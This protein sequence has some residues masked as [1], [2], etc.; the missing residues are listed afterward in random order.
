MLGTALM[1]TV[2]VL[3]AVEDDVAEDVAD[4]VVAADVE[5]G[6]EGVELLLVTADEQADSAATASTR[7]AIAT[8]RGRGKCRTA[9]G[10]CMKFPPQ[11]GDPW[12]GVDAGPR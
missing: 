5:A 9:R 6:V 7:A 2:V 4:G 8:A 3:L 12:V 10:R 1:P 11:N